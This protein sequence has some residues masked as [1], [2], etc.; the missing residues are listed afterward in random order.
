MIDLDLKKT[1][2][3]FGRLENF[4][5]ISLSVCLP[6]CLSAFL[7]L[8]AFLSVYLSVCLPF[9]LSAFLSVCLSACLPV[10]LSV[11]LSVC[12]PMCLSNF[13][14][15]HNLSFSLNVHSSVFVSTCHPIYLSV[16]L[17]IHTFIRS[18]VSHLIY[19]FMCECIPCLAINLSIC[20]RQ[21]VSLSVCPSNFLTVFMYKLFSSSPPL[22]LSSSLS[23]KPEW[24]QKMREKDN[25][26]L[27]PNVER[28]GSK[29][30]NHFWRNFTLMV[31]S[32]AY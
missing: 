7:S 26:C 29:V 12:T 1:F 5:I 17:S 24:I 30:I 8:P 14:S 10:C 27:R 16:H 23:N 21:F 13:I 9:C 28:S 31:L 11:C 15:V 19:V 6:F 3:G 20:D 32:S 4:K 22:L 18:F 25:V 2:A